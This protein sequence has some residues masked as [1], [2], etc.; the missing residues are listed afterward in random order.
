MYGMYLLQQQTEVLEYKNPIRKFWWSE[1][2]WKE[3]EE[4]EVT[5]T[6]MTMCKKRGKKIDLLVAYRQK[7]RAMQQRARANRSKWMNWLLKQIKQQL[8]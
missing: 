3:T 8:R 6:K 5:E 4:R 7:D 2:M 1:R